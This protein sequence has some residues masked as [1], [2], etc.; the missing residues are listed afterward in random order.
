MPAQIGRPAWRKPNGRRPSSR[1]E[2]FRT[3][4][5]CS[6]GRASHELMKATELSVASAVLMQKREIRLLELSKEFIPFDPFESIFRRPNIDPENTGVP[7]L[8]GGPD[9]RWTSVALLCPFPDCL[10]IR[11]RCAVA[12]WH[13]PLGLKPIESD[14]Q[15]CFSVKRCSRLL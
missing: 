2:R 1:A 3:R 12:H 11:S 6:F 4:W 7:V 8:F 13:F 15:L 5:Q 10:V 9:R 14:A